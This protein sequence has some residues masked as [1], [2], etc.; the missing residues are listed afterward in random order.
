MHSITVYALLNVQR[1]SRGFI[2]KGQCSD[3]SMD[4]LC[5]R[6]GHYM[7]LKCWA[8]DTQ[9]QSIICQKNELSAAMIQQSKT[10][11]ING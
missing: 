8:A 6:W 10:H 4:H 2:F 11:A 1:L 3:S 7:V 9:W 5:W